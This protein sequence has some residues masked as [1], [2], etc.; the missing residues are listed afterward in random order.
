MSPAE[1]RWRGAPA[2]EIDWDEQDQPHS[3]RFDDYYYSSEDGIAES[4]HVFVDGNRLVQRWQ[5]QQSPRFTMVET[6]FGTGLNFLNSWHNWRLYA[7]EQ[8]R[9]HYLSIE[10]YPLRFDELRR[11]LN[12]WQQLAPL[13][14][15][16]LQDY[17]PPLPGRHR[18]LFDQGRVC[19]DLVFDDINTAIE[20]LLELP[21]LEVN[22]WLLDGFTPARNPDM[23]Q[24]TL[25]QAMSRLGADNCSFATFTAASAVRTGLQAAGFDVEKRPGFGP[26]REMLCGT[27][28]TRTAKDDPTA[29]P[30]HLSRASYQEFNTGKGQGTQTDNSQHAIVIGAGLAGASI[31][32]FL[33]QRGWRVTVLEQGQLAGAASGNPQGVLYTRLSHR[34]SELNDF[35]LH[36]FCFASRFYQG[37]FSQGSLQAGRDG[38]L[39]GALHLRPD[40]S[41]EDPLFATV[42][43]L[44]ELVRPL[45]ADEAAARSGLAECPAGLYFPNSGW[46]HPAALCRTLLAA[47]GIDVLEHC[48]PLT[49]V[50]DEEQDGAGNWQAV[51]SDGSTLASA[52]SAIIAA[53]TESGRFPQLDW[54]KLQSIRGQTSQLPSRGPLRDLQT[55]ICHEGYISPASDGEHCIGATFDIADEASQTRVEDHQHNIEQLGR[56]LPQLQTQLETVVPAQLEGRV[57]FRCASPDYLP[58]VGP[59][60]DFDHFCQDYAALRRNARR[61]IPK[62]GSY[63][64]GLYV[65][66]GHGSRGLT[67]TPLA[68]ELLACQITGETPPVDVSLLRA[69]SPARFIVRD[70]VRNKL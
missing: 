56:H 46:M 54:L 26:K 21:D 40:W 24:D 49:L 47:P 33:A 41:E 34:P 15:C 4:A 29:T 14:D 18:L 50:Q 25:F 68:A 17:P 69:L 13:R 42:A 51:A 5:E 57:G 30:W 65:S 32:W 64:P 39:C 61:L 66:T 27:L 36:S 31:A 44:P 6:G 59:V 58:I 62:T 37:L 52:N 7:P 67:S 3:S 11:A 1:P 43:S 10:A 20:D 55:V 63:L 8:A 60:P 2:A 28:R 9:L 23:W 38:A 22:A 48:G 19:L 45:S 70:L 12:G 16:L 53:G 35:S